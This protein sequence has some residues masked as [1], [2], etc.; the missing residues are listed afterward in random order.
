VFPPAQ[1]R[2]FAAPAALRC[3][4]PLAPQRRP[5]SLSGPPPRKRRRCCP[6]I[7]CSPSLAAWPPLVALPRCCPSSCL[8]CVA[9]LLLSAPPLLLLT[10]PAPPRPPSSVSS[11]RPSLINRRLPSPQ[12]RTAVATRPPIHC[13]IS[14]AWPGPAASPTLGRR[15][16]SISRCS[17]LHQFCHLAP[18]LCR[19]AM[20]RRR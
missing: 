16:A 18:A 3:A 12:A 6:A 15:L 11:D 4:S 10:S 19:L 8:P 5:A 20:A 9:V 1:T 13:I 14:S 2:S 7:C 17:L